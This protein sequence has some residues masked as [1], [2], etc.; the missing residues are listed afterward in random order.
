M[1]W[2]LDTNVVSEGMKRHPAPRVA[3]WIASVNPARAFISVVTLAE[4]RSGIHRLPEGGRRRELDDWLSVDVVVGF[5]GRILDI[6]P[7]VADACG[8]LL[9]RNHL[10]RGAAVTMDVWIAAIATH[11]QLTVVTRN[12]RDFERLGVPVFDPWLE[13]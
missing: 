6:D 7:P 1:T 4:L 11:H 13:E 3:G 2:L 5:Q 9:A 10:D 12:T 8:R